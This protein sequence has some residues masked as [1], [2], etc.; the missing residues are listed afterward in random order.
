M[1]R[2]HYILFLL[3]LALVSAGRVCADEAS[4]QEEFVTAAD[5]TQYT[6]AQ[7]DSL[8]NTDD[9]IIA[10]LVIADKGDVL[11][12]EFGHAAIRMQCPTFEMDYVFTSESEDASNKVL[13]F[14]SGKLEMGDV[15]LPT[16]EYLD[17]Y[18]AEKRGVREYYFNLSP[19]QK[20]A[21]WQAWDNRITSD[22]TPYDYYE[23][24][25]ARVCRLAVE[26]AIGAN[27][28]HYAPWPARFQQTTRELARD[29][30]NDAGW[31]QWFICFVCGTEFDQVD[32]APKN[33]LIL[34]QDLLNAWIQASVDGHALLNS[35]AH[36]LVPEGKI[37]EAHWYS[38]IRV[39]CVLFALALL[40]W[41][42]EKK[43]IDWLILGLYSVIGF[44]M[45]YLLAFSN[46]CCTG[47]NWMILAFNPLPLLLWHWRIY[48]ALPYAI[49]LTIWIGVM[50]CVPH[51]L[52][53]SAH[54]M[55]IAGLIIILLKQSKINP[56]INN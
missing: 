19:K 33:K 23:R 28:I 14:L 37:P 46:L 56:I 47:W 35:Q 49:F 26:D 11:Y 7:M 40:S 13:A 27:T 54:M 53:G 41:F 3:M 8:R 51:V 21:L 1:K 45:F 5:G 52:V 12:A 4:N 25:C 43:Y 34:P 42:T 20:Q 17:V 6:Q 18:R 44:F 55:Q 29:A 15:A 9:F 10:S 38:P 50:L 32:I 22:V 39:M 24:G 48:W 30:S 16:E 2:L 31:T 36:E